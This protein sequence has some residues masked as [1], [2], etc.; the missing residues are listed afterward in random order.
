MKE[1]VVYL[2]YEIDEVVEVDEMEREWKEIY[3]PRTLSR[4]RV[5]GSNGMVGTKSIAAFGPL[6]IE[7]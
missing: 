2:E 6:S 3:G 7:H 1:M 4:E 5:W